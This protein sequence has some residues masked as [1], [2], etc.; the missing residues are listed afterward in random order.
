[1]RELARCGRALVVCNSFL[2]F[3]PP[4]NISSDLTHSRNSARSWER[5]DGVPYTRRGT[6]SR[7]PSWPSRR[8]VWLIFLVNC[9]AESWYV[10]RMRYFKARCVEL[11]HLHADFLALLPKWTQFL[12]GWPIFCETLFLTLGYASSFMRP[13]QSEITLLQ[14]LDHPRIVRYIDSLKTK[15]ALYI[16]LEYALTSLGASLL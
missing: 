15:T 8:S 5:V 12:L 13:P 2:F 11:R 9:S 14:S 1:M 6:C 3:A 7:T 16:V 10:L 4:A